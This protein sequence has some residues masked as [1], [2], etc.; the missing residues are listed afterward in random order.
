MIA[1]PAVSLYNNNTRHRYSV[2]CTP[3]DLL[4]KTPPKLEIDPR[5]A[6]SLLKTPTN[7]SMLHACKLSYRVFCYLVILH[8][9]LHFN[10][11]RPSLNYHGF[12]FPGFQIPDS[13]LH[14]PY[15]HIP[16]HISKHHHHRHH[17]HHHHPHHQHHH[18]HQHPQHPQH[19]T[20]PVL[21]RRDTCRQSFFDFNNTFLAVFHFFVTSCWPVSLESVPL[22]R[23]LKSHWCRIG[24]ATSQLLLSWRRLIC[25]T[26]H[27]QLLILIACTA[28]TPIH[29]DILDRSLVVCSPSRDL[30]NQPPYHCPCGGSLRSRKKI[31]W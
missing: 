18:H 19:F 15:S 12:R 11:L 14:F 20:G 21:S 27:L 8:C 26:L 1:V 7:V 4:A 30:P 9:L 24:F 23:T 16:Y 22:A 3:L 28:I 5:L 17:H 29:L 10:I 25:L 2:L 31:M 13:I 6:L